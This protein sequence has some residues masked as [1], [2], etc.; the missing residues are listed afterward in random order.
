MGFQGLN[1]NWESN[2][3]C[4][5][6]GGAAPATSINSAP[7]GWLAGCPVQSTLQWMA[8]QS[9]WCVRVCVR[10]PG[11]RLPVRCRVQGPVLAAHSSDPALCESATATASFQREVF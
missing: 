9:S 1:R 8:G 7:G 5:G 6:K 10:G 3:L 2:L 11:G 4:A